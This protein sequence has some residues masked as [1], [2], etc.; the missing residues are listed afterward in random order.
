MH[1]YVDDGWLSLKGLKEC[2][3]QERVFVLVGKAVQ[4]SDWQLCKTSPGKSCK[5]PLP[6]RAVLNG[7]SKRCIYRGSIFRIVALLAGRVGVFS[8]TNGRFLLMLFTN[9]GAY[10]LGCWKQTGSAANTMQIMNTKFED[11]MWLLAKDKTLILDGF[12]AE[13]FPKGSSGLGCWSNFDN[14]IQ[15]TIFW[16]LFSYMA[17]V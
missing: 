12:I 10:A 14:W 9:V 4:E 15:M 5:C 16:N 3:K 13:K 2:S 1:F 11:L 6:Q 8:R 17:H 7:R